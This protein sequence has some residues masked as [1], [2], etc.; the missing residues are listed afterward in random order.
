[1]KKYLFGFDISNDKI[2]E[3]KNFINQH[4]LQH[5]PTTIHNKISVAG[6]AIRGL[7][8]NETINDIDVYI[9]IGYKKIIQLKD[10]TK[11]SNVV[12]EKQYVY[13]VQFIFTD[14]YY[15]LEQIIGSFDLTCCQIGVNLEEIISS[16]MFYH[17]FKNKI[18]RP[19]YMGVY[20]Y[21]YLLRLQ[22]Y[23]QYG[24]TFNKITNNEMVYCM[25]NITND[26]IFDN[27][28]GS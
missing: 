12:Y 16:C 26:S 8:F 1:V 10:Y 14:S 18:L 6:G 9:P 23:I 7:I 4:V 25:E 28:S 17:D 22:K 3:I 19:T 27:Y 13:K 21:Q 20:S 11:L 24:Y 15:T 2:E 5:I